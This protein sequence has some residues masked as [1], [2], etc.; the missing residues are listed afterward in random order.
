MHYFK[1][2][3]LTIVKESSSKYEINNK[4]SSPK[5]IVNVLTHVLKI[6]EEA[7]EIFVLI[8]L[9]TKNKIT[10]IFEVSRGS[11]DSS[12][13]H[14]REVLKRALLNNSA[15]IVVAHNHPSE[16]PTPSKNDIN[17]TL[18]LKEASDLIGINLLDH[19]IIGGSRYCSL[20]EE[21]VL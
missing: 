6:Q 19:V 3:K 21:A 16:D 7:E 17:I 12:I 15:N 14:P 4:I 13:V 11:I 20:H 10:G 2:Y 1:K 5:D 9:D 8:T 18:R